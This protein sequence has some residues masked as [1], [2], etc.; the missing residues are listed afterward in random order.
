MEAAAA[1]QSLWCAEPFSALSAF[2]THT[3]GVGLS[4]ED[5]LQFWEREFTKVM[6]TDVFNKQYAYS[7][8]HYFGK[9]G[10]RKDYTPYNC[11]KIILGTGP[12]HGEYHGCPFKHYDEANLNK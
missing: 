7:V 9:E 4:L 8:R 2:P 1:M 11:S 10:R 5:A 6:T 12:G 3:Q